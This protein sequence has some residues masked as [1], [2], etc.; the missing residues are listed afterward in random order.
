[1]HVAKEL[2]G[3]IGLVAVAAFLGSLAYVALIGGV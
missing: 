1:M 3:A 2:T